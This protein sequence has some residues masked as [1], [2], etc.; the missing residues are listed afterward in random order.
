[1]NGRKG[2]NTDQRLDFDSRRGVWPC[3]FADNGTVVNRTSDDL[4]R[5]VGLSGITSIGG[6]KEETPRWWLK[7]AQWVVVIVSLGGLLT[8]TVTATARILGG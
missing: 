1:M 8:V 3:S 5:S 4:Y 7:S 2:S 6:V